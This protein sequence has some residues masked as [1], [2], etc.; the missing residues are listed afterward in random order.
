MSH[1]DVDQ[2][3]QAS[4]F[5]RIDARVKL[6]CTVGLAVVAALL[7]SFWAIAL[8][9]AFVVLMTIVS[10]LPARHLLRNYAYALV[11]ILFAT[12]TMLLTS[13]VEAAAAMFMRI[14]ASVLALILLVATTPF[15]QLLEALHALH[16]PRILCSL[17]MFT[18]RFI[19][20]LLEEVSHMNLARKARGFEGGRNVLDREAFGTLSA[21]MGMAFVRAYSRA[22]NI[23]DALLS[24]GYSGEI[25]M[26]GM[27]RAGGPEVV[28]AAVFVL[29][30]MAAI[31][32][33]MGVLSWPL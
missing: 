12:L 18:Y 4:R 10:G 8:L 26:R 21:T 6:I 30:G 7:T 25:R 1:L 28:L 31:L 27:K 22:S 23:Y 19:F 9:F 33:Q 2:F 5:F 24:R 3:A 29:A 20:V 32:V 13:G 16:M 14:S 15:F 17:I 11:F